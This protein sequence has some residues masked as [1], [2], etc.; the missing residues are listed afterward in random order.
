[1][2][3]YRAHAPGEHYLRL[4]GD[5]DITT[6]VCVDQLSV[7]SRVETQ[8]SFLRRFGI[9][10]LVEEGRRAWA[11]AASRPDLAAM[12]MRSRLREAEAL[13]EPQGL[14]GFHSVTWRLPNANAMRGEM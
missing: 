12:V 1:M 6:H 2:R 10:E 5:Q 3:T 14:G 13:M 7:P 11:A 8:A 9:D 4:A